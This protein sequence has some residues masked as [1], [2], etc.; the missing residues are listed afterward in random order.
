LAGDSASLKTSSI[1]LLHAASSTTMYCIHV[2]TTMCERAT[3]PFDIET[4]MISYPTAFAVDLS[5]LLSSLAALS[6]AQHCIR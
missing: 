2:I 4:S 3:L 6:A 5:R 1:I